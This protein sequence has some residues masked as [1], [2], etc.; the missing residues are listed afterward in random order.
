MIDVQLDS[1][2]ADAR[3]KRLAKGLSPKAILVAGQRAVNAAAVTARKEWG[4]EIRKTVNLKAKPVRDALKIEKAFGS[5]AQARIDIS[6]EAIP[7]RDYGLKQFSSGLRAKVFRSG[8]RTTIKTDPANNIGAFI[9]DAI[10]GHGFLRKGEKVRPKQGQVSGQDS[11][12]EAQNAGKPYE[13]QPLIKLW[14]P[15]I[16]RIAEDTVETQRTRLLQARLSPELERQI[17]LAID[18]ANR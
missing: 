1:S 17:K 8:G 14:G 11:K 4:Q 15:S 6:Q 13:R 16:R 7:L 2:E 5:K 9:T 3:L 12:V 18:K 10:G